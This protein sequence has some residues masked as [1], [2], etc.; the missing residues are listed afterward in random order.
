MGQGKEACG[1]NKAT[2]ICSVTMTRWLRLLLA[3]CVEKVLSGVGIIF[4]RAADALEVC[5]REGRLNLSRV[6]RLP[7]HALLEGIASRSRRSTRF[8]ADF[9]HTI[10]S[11]FSTQSANCGHHEAL[12]PSR[13]VTK[14]ELR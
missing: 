4:P 6:V 12:R 9:T 2:V 10:F 14:A 1:S 13:N 11:T 7:S 3:D 8:V 5:R